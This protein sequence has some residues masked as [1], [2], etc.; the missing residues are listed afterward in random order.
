MF[1]KGRVGDDMGVCGAVN[2][3]QQ[4][5]TG[6]VHE[7]HTAQIERELLLCGKRRF[8]CQPRLLAFRYP[9]ADHSSFQLH[10][11]TLG[12]VVDCR[13]K[14]KNSPIVR[15]T[16]VCTLTTMG[17]EDHV[18][19]GRGQKTGELGR[20]REDFREDFDVRDDALTRRYFVAPTKC[21]PTV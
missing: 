13:S 4:L 11:E 1:C 20:Q 3:P 12:L 21:S 17:E 15:Y 9:G 5:E 8:K 16:I 14:R 19:C 7:G 10:E 2:L 6:L 18:D